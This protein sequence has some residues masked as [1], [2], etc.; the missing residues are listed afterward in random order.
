MVQP[1]SMELVS[2]DD[3]RH[4]SVAARPVPRSG[5]GCEVEQGVLPSA[6]VA[7]ARNGRLVA[8]E[9]YGDATN[10]RRYITQSVGRNVVAA[11]VWKL[12]GDGLLRRSTNELAT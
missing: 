3:V 4:R 1:M 5:C 2:P 12:L 10:E 8:F 9:T 11:A 6:Q 7:V